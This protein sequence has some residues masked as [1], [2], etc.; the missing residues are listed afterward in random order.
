[1]IR[2]LERLL[3]LGEPDLTL[4]RGDGQ[5]YMRR[6]WVLPRSKSRWNLYLHNIV[7]DDDDRALHDHPGWN[8]SI[9]LRGGYW[10]H[11]PGGDIKWRGPGT[12]L[13]RRADALHR[14]SL[15]AGGRGAWT[16]WLSGRKVRKWGF[17]CP[18][19]RW[20]DWETF[21]GFQGGSENYKGAQPSGGPGCGE[22]D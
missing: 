22:Y 17:M 20:V 13:F 21:T 11:L 4:I 19:G 9:I 5:T 1:M 7:G 12:I 18:E 8:L 16:L 14:L 6:W 2:A 3:G 15:P 10:E